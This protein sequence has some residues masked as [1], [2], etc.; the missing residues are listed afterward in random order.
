MER[1]SDGG[2]GEIARGGGLERARGSRW[3]DGRPR[4]GCLHL[5]LPLFIY[6]LSLGV[7]NIM[8]NYIIMVNYRQARNTY[9]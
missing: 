2:L 5:G 7:P 9:R 4:I 6:R 8:V 3:R 1:R